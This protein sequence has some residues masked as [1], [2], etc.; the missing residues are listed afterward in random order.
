[1]EVHALPQNKF[2]LGRGPG[3]HM[4][5]Q[6]SGLY[7]SLVVSTL[8]LPQLCHAQVKGAVGIAS[9]VTIEGS[10]LEPEKLSVTDDDKLTSLLKVP[11]GFKVQVY[12]RELINPRMLAVSAD[13]TVYA[14]RRTVGDVV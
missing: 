14:T 6:K 7:M 2:V 3:E 5:L 10:I 1:M 8:L 9:D 12:A 13:G 11:Q 4:A